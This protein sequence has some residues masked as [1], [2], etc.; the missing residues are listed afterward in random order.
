MFIAHVPAGYLLS[1]VCQK[2]VGE[3]SRAL[4]MW[5]ILAGSIIPDLDMIY[6]WMMQERAVHHH[7]YLPHL[8][9]VW[10][11]VLMVGGLISLITRKQIWGQG[12]WWM[13]VGAMFHLLLDTL[14]GGI[15]WLHPFD[16]TLFH[17]V[18]VPATQSWWV[19]S[20]VLH[21]T[22]F[23]E[24]L[25]CIASG[26]VFLLQDADRLVR[27]LNRMKRIFM[28]CILPVLGIAIAFV[29]LIYDVLFA[30]IPYL[31]PTP[32]M[33]ARYDTHSMIAACFYVIGGIA[34]LVGLIVV[35]LVAIINHRRTVKLPPS[36][37]SA[38][39]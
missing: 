13:F 16:D 21:W 24:I 23:A 7:L 2:R 20:F 31:D 5:C 38:N 34:L 29:G 26:L 37:A 27:F 33:Q 10:I 36:G 32:E 14:V 25:I 9:S 6:F 19:M 28:L 18:D 11:G 8:P 39:D 35:P 12:A 15:A 1:K 22:F 4:V 17:L 3:K 30:G